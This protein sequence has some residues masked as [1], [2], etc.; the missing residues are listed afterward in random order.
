MSIYAGRLSRKNFALGLVLIFVATLLLFFV[1]GMFAAISLASEREKAKDS[2]DN[3]QQLS[4]QLDQVLQ[5]AN[6]EIA[7]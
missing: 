5:K 1:L 4:Q 6:T 3:S 7:I 2:Y